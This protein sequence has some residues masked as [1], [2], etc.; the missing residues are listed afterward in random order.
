MCTPSRLGPAD[1]DPDDE[2]DNTPG[3]NPPDDEGGYSDDE[4][5]HDEDDGLNAQ[6]RVFMQLSE[7]I[8]NLVHNNCHTS[9]SDDS[10]VK[11]HEPDTFDGS[12]P[13]KLRTFFVQCELNFQR[14]PK[15]FR[16]D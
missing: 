2:D 11:V 4:P 9:S 1:E 8:N 12:D 10:K 3:R 15:T 5:D 6:D 16:S 7:A 13:R 14:K